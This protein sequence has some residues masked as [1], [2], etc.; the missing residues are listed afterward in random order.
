MPNVGHFTISN[1]NITSYFISGR[2]N[3]VTSSFAEE[4]WLP[5]QSTTSGID[6]FRFSILLI[7]LFNKLF[8]CFD[9]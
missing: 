5:P 3:P 2:W 7:L 8:R 1:L 6:Y 4:F 9:T